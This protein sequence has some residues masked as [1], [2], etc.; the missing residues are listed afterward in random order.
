MSFQ[1]SFE[2]KK[3]ISKAKNTAL[4]LNLLSN[5]LRYTPDGGN[6]TVRLTPDSDGVTVP[7]IDTGA[8]IPPE[9]LPHVFDRFYRVDRSRTR[10]T[11]D[12]G[13]GLA[14]VKQVVEAQN[15][16]V[17]ADSTEGKGSTFAFCIP[18]SS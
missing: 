6:I 7:V 10:S 1:T 8:G 13:L 5:A 15:G 18:Y 16:H 9:D 11:G 14:I 3:V 4:T 17:W 12:S 2:A